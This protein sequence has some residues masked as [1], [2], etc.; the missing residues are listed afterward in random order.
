MDNKQKMRCPAGVPGGIVATLIG[1]AGM[2]YYIINFQ[3]MGL[4]VST[5]LFLI[6]LPFIRVTMMIHAANDRLDEIEEKLKSK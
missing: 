6:A 2:V 3:W 5:G 1:L 4:A